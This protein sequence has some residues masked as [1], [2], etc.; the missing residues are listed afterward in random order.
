[1]NGNTEPFRL[2]IDIADRG[3]GL[4]KQPE[5]PSIKDK[6]AGKG[7]ARGWGVFLIQNLVDEVKFEHGARGGSVISLV[8]HL[9]EQERD[10]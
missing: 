9:K 2:Q 10:S 4:A 1:M 7:S 8:L 3:K 6:M 5:V